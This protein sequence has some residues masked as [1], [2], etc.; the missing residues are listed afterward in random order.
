[1]SANLFN[2]RRITNIMCNIKIV[3]IHTYYLVIGGNA[4]T[5]TKFKK[6]ENS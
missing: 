5:M 4:T 3:P 2:T 6:K 1:M